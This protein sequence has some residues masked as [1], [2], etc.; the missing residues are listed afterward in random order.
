MTERFT[1][2]L[3]RKLATLE[4]NNSEMVSA[5]LAFGIESYIEGAMDCDALTQE[6]YFAALERLEEVK[7]RKGVI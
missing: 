6:E 4:K 1:K 5:A 2:R 3:D 7:A